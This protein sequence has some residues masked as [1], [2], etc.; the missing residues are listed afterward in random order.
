MCMIENGDGAV[1]MIEDGRFFRAMLEHKCAECRRVIKRGERY[2]AE[3]YIFEGKLTRHKTCAH[4]MVVRNWLQDECGGW[5]FGAVEE[6]AREHVHNNGH[7]YGRD[8]Y[9]AV[10]GMAWNWRA[11][12][13]RMLPVPQPIKTSEEIARAEGR[14]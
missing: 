10:V 1:T 14:S 6:D 5:L 7:L 12:S 11:P 2:H 4:C 8:L 3:V 13:G 9:R